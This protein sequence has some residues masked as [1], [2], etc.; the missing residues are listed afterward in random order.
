MYKI[1]TTPWDYIMQFPVSGKEFRNM[2]IYQELAPSSN[3]IATVRYEQDEQAAAPECAHDSEWYE[4]I[5]M[6]SSPHGHG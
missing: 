6:Q 3:I 4:C 2:D 5:L 1:F